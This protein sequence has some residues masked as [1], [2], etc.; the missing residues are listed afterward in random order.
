V[1]RVAD[2]KQAGD[3]VGRMVASHSNGL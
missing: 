1:W 2:R 3:W